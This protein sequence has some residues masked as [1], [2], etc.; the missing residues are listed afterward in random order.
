MLDW[1]RNPFTDRNPNPNQSQVEQLN[2]ELKAQ[3]VE[4]IAH[5]DDGAGDPTACHSYGE[6]LASVDKNYTDATQ[7]YLKNC[8]EKKY[9]A[10]CFNLGRFYCKA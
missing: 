9:G 10:S 6:W 4:Y 7:V 1:L 2:E 8:H 5:C 3:H